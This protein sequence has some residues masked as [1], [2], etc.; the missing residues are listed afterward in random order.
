MVVALQSSLAPIYRRE[1][2]F[3]DIPG[4]RL[5]NNGSDIGPTS[6]F[7]ILIRVMGKG[8]TDDLG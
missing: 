4:V 6:L 8:R 3:F 5:R 2:R 7:Q 1:W